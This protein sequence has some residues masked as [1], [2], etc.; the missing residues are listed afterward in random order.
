M[1]IEIVTKYATI[2]LAALGLFSVIAKVTPNETDNK[3]VDFLYKI[4]NFLG[5]TKT[6]E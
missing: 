2:I 6:E 3:I 4:V 5:L 1:N